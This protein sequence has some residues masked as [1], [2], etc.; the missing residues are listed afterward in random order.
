MNKPQTADK[1][2]ERE[3]RLIH[4]AKRELGL[5]NDTYR[6]MLFALARVRSSSDLDWTGRKKVLDHMKASGFKVRNSPANKNAKDGEYR[7]VRALWKEL[8]AIGAVEHDTDDAVRAYVKRMTKIDDFKFLNGWQTRSV[9]E[10]LKK[11][12]KRVELDARLT[13]ADP[14]LTKETNA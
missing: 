14:T 1:I 13:R 12:I 2:R 4:V 7:K 3:I 8:H 10:S 6:D 11:W 9:I 5:D